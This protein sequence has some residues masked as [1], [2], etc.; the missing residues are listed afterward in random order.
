MSEFAP[1]DIL[2]KKFAKR[3]TGYAPIEVHD[4]LSDL[5]RAVEELLRERGELRQRLHNLEQELRAFRERESALK[6]ALVAAQRSAET[7]IEV[8]RAEGQRI[9][10]EG[11]G[12]AERLVAEADERVQN[13]ERVLV[14]PMLNERGRL[15]AIARE[16]AAGIEASGF[17]VDAKGTLPLNEQ[18]GVFAKLGFMMWDADGSNALNGLDDDGTDLH[19]GI[20]AQYMFNEQ[21]G[22]VGEWEAVDFDDENV[23]LLSVGAMMKF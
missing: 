12:L 21:I 5:A 13:M 1:M 16:V 18:F 9:V 17:I 15:L 8:A 10:A 7:T 23:D 3:L 6:E 20:G 2:G 11:H 19:Y 22:I 4:Y 14:D